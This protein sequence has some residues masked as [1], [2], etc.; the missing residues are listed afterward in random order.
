VLEIAA[1]AQLTVDRLTEEMTM[2]REAP[3]GLDWN[4][5]HPV[6]EFCFSNPQDLQMIET[7]PQAR[8][9]FDLPQASG[10][11][12]MEE[13]RKRNRE[14]FEEVQYK[15]FREEQWEIIRKIRD[16]AMFAEA[17]NHTP[18]PAA[19]VPV[20]LK[21]APV[22]NGKPTGYLP[23]TVR[24]ATSEGRIHLQTL[25]LKVCA[26]LRQDPRGHWACDL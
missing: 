24:H 17:E 19:R 1:T 4:W 2:A 10:P 9:L 13:M 12:S 3:A 25:Y 14:R 21:N 20:I 5:V 23:V 22:V 8:A 7:S 6:M 11:Q 16:A 26:S 18:I 15:F